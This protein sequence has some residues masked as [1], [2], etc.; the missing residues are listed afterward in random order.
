MATF[1]SRVKSLG[2]ELSD[3]ISERL[4]HALEIQEA[5]GGEEGEGGEAEAEG[6][7]R[8]PSVSI[9]I[10]TAAPEELRG[11]VR[12]QAAHIAKLEGRCREVIEAYKRVA[13]E[14]AQ[15]QKELQG[16]AESDQAGGGQR[17]GLFDKNT[18][19]QTFTLI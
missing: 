2:T 13:G 8:A 7:S 5:E 9:N 1:L 19:S 16:K 11:F 4:K 17:Q 10:E 15:L 18:T 3:G 12:R 14:R 6:T